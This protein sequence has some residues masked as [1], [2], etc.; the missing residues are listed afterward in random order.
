MTRPKA[1]I[2]DIGNVLITWNPERLY[3]QLLPDRAE[4]DALF[5]EVDLHG[6]NDQIDRGANFRDT[7][8]AH[9]E[10]YPHYADL[11]RVWHDRWIEMASP[12]IDGSWDILHRLR[13]QGTPVHALSNFGIES[14]AYAETQ[15][16]ML[17]DFDQRFISGH[18]GVIKPEVRI[19]EMVEEALGLQ[20]AD[21]FFTDDRADNIEMAAARGWSTYQFQTPEGLDA[22]LR[23]LGTL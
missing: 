4:R 17:S 10:K 2:F 22:A 13:A 9:A 3:D 11:I 21:L 5:A 23:E 14:F 18:M 8:Y 15:Y 7:V 20:G 1:V 6:M 19:Y 16:P 12:L